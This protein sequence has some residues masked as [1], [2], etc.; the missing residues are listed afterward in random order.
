MYYYN[1]EYIFWLL[2]S[3]VH[4]TS[5]DLKKNSESIIDMCYSKYHAV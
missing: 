3:C 1:N 4:N 2:L 5:N